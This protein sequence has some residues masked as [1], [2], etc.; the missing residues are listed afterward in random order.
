M[1]PITLAIVAALT[2]G[3][4]AG[5]TKVGE[6]AIVD[7][8]NGLKSLIQRKFGADSKAAR[9]VQD[10]E[11]EPDSKGAAITLNEQVQKA[12]ADQDQE[13][14]QSAQALLEKLK[15]QPGSAQIVQNVVG[16]YNALAANHSTATVNVNIPRT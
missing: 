12:K 7:I 3:V 10:L 2:A 4:T 16:S 8:Y 6:Q 9:A 11:D 15:A 1:D 5:V 13:L 14:L